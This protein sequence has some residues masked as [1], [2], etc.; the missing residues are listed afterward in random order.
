MSS[1]SR[2]ASG[3]VA[4]PE[5]VLAGAAIV[6]VLLAVAVIVAATHLAVW[7]DG[8]HQRLAGNPVA[9]IGDLVRGR[10]R[11]PARIVPIAATLG[12]LLIAV[13]GVVAWGMRGFWRANVDRAARWTGQ[14]KEIGRLSSRAATRVATRLGVRTPGLPI[15]RAVRGGQMLWAGWED[16]AVDIWGPRTGKTTSRAIPSILAAPGAVLATSNKRDV[17]D[18]TRDVRARQG[19]VWV[20]DPQ[21]IADEAPSW[22]WNPLSYVLDERRAAEL[23]DVFASCS[24]DAGAKTDAFFDTAGQNLV[25]YLLLAA[26]LERRPLTQVYLWL[27]QPNNDEPAVGLREHGY[28]VIAS[29][30]Q[31]QINAPEKQRGG[32]FGTAQEMCSFM[33]NRGAMRWVINDPDRPVPVFDPHA[34]AGSCDTLYSLSKEGK[35]SAAPLVTALTLAV[36]EAAEDRAKRCR[37]GRLPV[38][39]VAVLDEAANVCRWRKLPDLY[40]HYG[41]RGIC[42][43]TILQSWSQG[44]EVWGRDG[45]RKLWSAATVKVYGG[46]VSEVEFLEEI[47]KLIGDYDLLARQ[48][49]HGVRQGR[50]TSRSV[51][52]ERILDVADLGS[53]PP[54][55]VVVFASGSRPV[56]ARSVPWMTGADA[57]A[58]RAS[59]AAHD[60]VNVTGTGATR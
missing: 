8:S 32:V 36:C 60:P 49:T 59:I 11:W 30:L 6:V 54:G 34:F 53:L 26:A 31:A 4:D 19:P 12:G 47:S 52:R 33:T 21:E 57:D 24:R 40:S 9:L 51:R 16:A 58:I 10:E 7:V 46:G 18:A 48:E 20:F 22:C 44:V 37:A 35:G 45:M 17:V 23:A 13:A 38:P 28:A 43:L 29:A 39:M 27:T 5:M 14:G 25:A 2:R 3:P 15:A 41:S 1:T 50:S 56:L 42:L 55:R